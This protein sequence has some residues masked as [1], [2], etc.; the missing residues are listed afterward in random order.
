M[1]LA[2]T[3]ITLCT[4]IETLDTSGIPSLTVKVIYLRIVEDAESIEKFD[5]FEIYSL[6]SFTELIVHPLSSESELSSLNAHSTG[7][8]S[9][10]LLETIKPTL[11]SWQ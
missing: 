3:L 9:D 5:G 11:H 10:T 6:S 2:I 4:S 7:T 1:Q 8:P